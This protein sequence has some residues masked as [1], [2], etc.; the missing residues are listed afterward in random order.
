VSLRIERVTDETGAV[1]FHDVEREATPVDHPGLVADP[2]DD[3]V[4]MLNHPVPT[5]HVAFYV[6]YEGD[7]VVASG[8]FAMPMLENRHICNVHTT[9]ALDA[10]GRGIGT[11]MARFLIGE[12]RK[13][14]RSVAQAHV[15][16]PLEGSSPGEALA[17]KLGAKAALGSI[18]RQLRLADV[19]RAE[20]ES[21]T[22]ELL[23]GPAASYELVGWQDHC[24]DQFADRAAQIVPLVM[25]DS[26]RG[27]LDLEVEVW[28]ATRYRE[29]EGMIAARSRHQLVTAA[30]D[31][32]NGRLVA[33]TDLNVPKSD[34]RVVAQLGTAVERDHRGHRLGLLVKTANLLSLM[35]RFPDAE[36]I[37]TY[38]A[39][40]NEHMIAVN[41]ELGFR[42]VERSTAF[43]L[44]I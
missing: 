22:D 39:A 41:S 23:A 3:I 19:E 2:L 20:L 34:H 1:A 6:G 7:A 5:F 35:D 37:Q 33:M 4:G 38:N 11:A 21:R 44:S 42:P 16:G 43:Q 36:S 14:G 13:E 8:F 25:S 28:D 40:A 18:R 15:Y 27:D 26:P 17:T 32:T 30:I 29:Y 10:R 9:V 24:P 31:R 12:G